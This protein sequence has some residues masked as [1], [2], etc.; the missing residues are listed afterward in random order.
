MLRHRPIHSDREHGVGRCIRQ[1][2]AQPPIERRIVAGIE[3][4]CVPNEWP[5]RQGLKAPVHARSA[6]AHGD[7]DEKESLVLICFSDRGSLDRA[8]IEHGCPER[9]AAQVAREYLVPVDMSR[10]HR[11]E[12]SWDVGA[13]NDVG[14]RREGVIPWPNAR[15]FDALMQAEESHIGVDVA[16]SRRL[17]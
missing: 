17:Q 6:I 1:Q 8:G 9:A 5:S 3:V 13:A 12:A 15:P 7:L 14:C 4:E 2:R 16:P 11:V 10:Q